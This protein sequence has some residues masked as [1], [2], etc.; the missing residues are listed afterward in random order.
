MPSLALT[1]DDGPDP[2]WTPKLLDLLRTLGARAT[3]FPIAARAAEHAAII[4]RARAEGHAI[5]LHCDQHVRHSE[6]DATWLEQDTD[7]A[8]ERLAALGVTPTFWRTPWGDTA[9]WSVQIARDRNLRLI[10]WTVDTHD[11]RG[12]S[13]A[14]MFEAT[15]QE[16]T[17][18]AI[19]LAHDGL[20]PGARRDDPEATLEYVALAGEHAR[21]R[22][23]RLEALGAG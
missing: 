19:V 14:E 10:G 5:G 9:P 2:V 16:L 18:G 23:L 21:D 13:G 11:W 7:A 12:D 1:F 3:F 22:G 15:R 6:R 8:L 17:E 4:E 20:G